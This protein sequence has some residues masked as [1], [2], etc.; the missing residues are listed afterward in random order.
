MSDFLQYRHLKITIFYQVPLNSLGGRLKGRRVS[1]LQG[2][3]VLYR[4]TTLWSCCES[5][6]RPSRYLAE[7]LGQQQGGYATGV[8]LSD[9]VRQLAYYAFL[10]SILILLRLRQEQMRL[11]IDGLRRLAHAVQ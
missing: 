1:A 11:E 9:G 7:L 5:Q 8:M 6:F 4:D 2:L 10:A 3:F